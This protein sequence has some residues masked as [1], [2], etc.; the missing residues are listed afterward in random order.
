MGATQ[1][2]FARWNSRWLPA[3]V[4]D[5]DVNPLT[6]QDRAR[7]RK[8][9]IRRREKEWHTWTFPPAISSAD[10]AS[11]RL[12]PRIAIIS[13]ADI[14][15]RESSVTEREEEEEEEEEEKGERARGREREKKENREKREQRE[16]AKRA[17]WQAECSRASEAVASRIRR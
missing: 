5:D 4:H 17:S 13:A 14:V 2:R 8:V 15:C 9:C 12:H 11:V 10:S 1:V 3:L 6:P 7:D 16:D